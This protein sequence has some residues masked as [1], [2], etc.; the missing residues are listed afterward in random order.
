M[1]ECTD[2]GAEAME[3]RLM[4]RDCRCV[5]RKKLRDQNIDEYRRKERE[6]NHANKEKVAKRNSTYREANREKHRE[7]YKRSDAKRRAEGYFTSE[8]YRK[9][10][11]EYMREWRKKNKDRVNAT[12]RVAWAVMR[13][14]LIRPQECK[15]GSTDRI[16]AHHEDY[17]KPLDVIWLC[18][19]CHLAVHGKELR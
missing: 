16:E 13:G 7:Y 19:R 10:N 5:R 8:Q 1:R 17:S 2:C 6:Y 3:G 4:C 9:I 15:C 14:D 12:A 18:K 11:R